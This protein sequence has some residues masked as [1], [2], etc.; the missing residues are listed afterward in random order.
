MILNDGDHTDQQ[1]VSFEMEFKVRNVQSYDNLVSNTTR[2]EEDDSYY[3][4]FLAQERYNNYDSFL[5]DYLPTI[6]KEYDTLKFRKVQK[7]INAERVIAKYYSGSGATLTGFGI[8]PQDAFFSNGTDTVNISFIEDKVVNFTMVFSYPDQRLYIYNNGVITGVVANS[9]SNT[10]S[11]A[12]DKLVFNSTYCDIDL[13]KFRIYKTALNVNEVVQNYAVDKKNI[14]IY[15]QN[16]LA[17][18]NFALGEY[19]FD[20]QAMLDYNEAHPNAP[21]MPY[22]IYDTSRQTSD[23]LSYAK[24]IKIP[25]D[26]EFVNTPL[27]LAYRNGELLALAIEDGLCTAS[28]SA[29][30]KEAAVKEYYLH[31]CPSFISTNA[32][33]AVQGTSS[34]FYPR[35]NYK[36]KTQTKFDADKQKRTHIY[37]NRGPF[38]NDFLADQ[39]LTKNFTEFADPTTGEAYKLKSAQDFF[40]MD[41]Y[42]VG[43]T[44]FTMKID[45]MESSGTYNTGFANLVAN[46]YSKHPLSDYNKAGA[47][48]QTAYEKDSS[49]SFD[50]NKT[51]YEDSKGKTKAEVTAET[52][53]PNKYYITTYQPYQFNHLSDYRTSVQ[54]YRVLA[55]HKKKVAGTSGSNYEFIGLYNMNIDKGSDEIYG[56]KPDKSIVGSYLKN[57][58]ISK[59]AEC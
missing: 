16:A 17:K 24:K 26:F 2:Y 22:V 55:F 43:T 41:N 37:L 32:E 33:M 51:Y 35:R 52:Y 11:I 47:F 3:E 28:S 59:K 9:V 19:Q 1:S 58:S 21:L 46:A 8:G 29:E 18:S 15:D 4:A 45:Y 48:A 39:E 44:K 42:T 12:T 27:E 13:Y 30:V 20:Y 25:I 38:L 53:Q 49:N 5:H 7:D 6:G 40:Y 57:K 54:G 31:H 36:I 56:F 23:Q 14:D 34:Q 50:E 10:F